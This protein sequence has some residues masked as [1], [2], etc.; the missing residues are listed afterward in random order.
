MSFTVTANTGYNIATVTGCGGSLSGSTYTTGAIAGAC[1][2][3]ASF[4]AAITYTVTATA[5]SNG[6]ISPVGAS[7]VISGQSQSFTVTA[8]NGYDIATVTGC[9]GSLSGSTYTTGAITG[10]CTVTAGFTTSAAITDSITGMVLLK[11]PSGTYTMGDTFGDGSSDE[12]PTHQV[13]VG[14]FYIGKYQ[15]T[16]GQWQAVMGSNPSSFSSCGADCP[17]ESVNFSDIQAFITTLNQ[18]SG[19]NYRLP[20]EAEWEYAARSGGQSQEYSGGS[21]INA[22]AWYVGNSGGTT[23]PVGQKQ[24]NGLGLYDMSGNVDE[25][26]SDWFALSYSAAAQTNP[27]GPATGLPPYL[28]GR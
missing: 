5:G 7:T 11:A 25:L 17:V 6:A 8:N 13:T 15:V 27:T 10:A 20:T 24:A 3:T 28:S 26:V 1:T 18:L 23:H 19:K 12:L 4:S 21:D 16:Q 22:V 14:E 2:V 9:G